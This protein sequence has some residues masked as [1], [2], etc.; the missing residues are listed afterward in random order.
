ML[1]ILEKFNLKKYIFFSVPLIKI[2]MELSS[3]NDAFYEVK[4]ILMQYLFLCLAKFGN[5]I[6]WFI[7]I[8]KIH[9]KKIDNVKNMEI[10]EIRNETCDN[11]GEIE[12]KQQLNSNILKGLSQKELNK[13]EK[14]IKIKKK[15][16]KELFILIISSFLDF[17]SN[18]SYLV[19]YAYIYHN[20]N[21]SSNSN[22][23]NNATYYMM[24]GM[25][26]KINN[27]KNNSTNR[28]EDNKKENVINIIPFRIS[29]RIFIMYTLSFFILYSERH[30]RHQT[31]SLLLI[32]IIIIFFYILDFL[33]KIIVINDNLLTHIII[34]FAQE[35]LFCL[36]N[37]IGAKFLSISNG[38]VYKLLFFNGLFG[39]LIIIIINLLNGLIHCSDFKLKDNYCEGDNLKN[40][41]NLDINAKKL[42][43]FI[44]SLILSIIEMACTWLLIFYKTVNHLSIACAIH[45]NLRFLIDRINNNNIFYSILPFIC[46]IL[47]V[48]FSFV[49]NEII[50]LRFCNLEK[51]TSEEI[52]KR[53][54]EDKSF[55]DNSSLENS[56]NTEE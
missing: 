13:Y 47:V 1:F 4:N 46:F 5:F 40:L 55:N 9:P 16:Y 6:F 20:N 2:I 11:E 26:E 21:D 19:S 37:V 18:F 14:E 33:L 27:N 36:D 52:E 28:Q 23:T 8:K 54:I 24:D 41:F 51:N 45:L 34:T 50:I 22:S 32:I 39:L 7:L 15:N 10:D 38:N 49:Y 35:F 29:I 56:I 30:Y 17:I 25:T 48:F 42:I 31:L 43:K 44:I 3:F 53:A 12:K